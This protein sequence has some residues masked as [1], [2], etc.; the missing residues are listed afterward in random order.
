[1]ATSSRRLPRHEILCSP[2]HGWY[3]SRFD[4]D[5]QEKGERT[6]A[7]YRRIGH[8]LGYSRA[9][10]LLVN[11]DVYAPTPLGIRHVLVAGSQ[12]VHISAPGE[13]EPQLDAALTV[14]R[15]DLEGR[16]LTPGLIDGHVHVTGGGGEDGPQSAVPA[17]PFTA[18][19]LSGAT[20]VIGLSGT[21]DEIRTTASLLAR[22]RALRHEGLSA[23]C[24]TGGYH[25]PPTTLTGSVRG[26]ITHLDPVIG[27]GELAISDH[28]SSHPTDQELLRIAS[29]AHVA[30]LLTGK[31]GVVHLHVGDGTGG[32]DPIR[33]V[34]DSSEVPAAALH[35]THV[36]RHPALL[37]DAYKLAREHPL[38]LDVTALPLFQDD[39]MIPA[40]RAIGQWFDHDLPAGR[41]T[42]SSDAGGS[43]PTFDAQGRVVGR[44]TGRPDTLIGALAALIAEGR[45]LAQALAPFTVNPARLWRLH[46]KGH[47]RIG[48]DADLVVLDEDHLPLHVVA[49][50][51]IVVWDREAIVHGTFERSPR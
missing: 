15:V 13:K 18:F 7:T 11:A 20:T 25:V 49:R 42:V 50:G 4:A 19:T 14:Q 1:M 36:N 29:D 9:M 24:L 35:P 46:D 47:V 48:A 34:L 32:L 31:A 51:R 30:G 16:R 39:P 10:L 41:I 23:W 22:T 27:V 44:D 21:D 3:R 17:L 28:R 5:C 12:I 43:L 37:E 6:A 45:P 40:E 2:L 8:M 38:T 33:R 26:D